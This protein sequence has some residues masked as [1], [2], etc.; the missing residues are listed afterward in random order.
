MSIKILKPAVM[1]TLVSDGR[2]GFRNLGIGPGGAMDYV[3]MKTSNFLTGSDE[4]AVLEMG[5]SSAEILFCNNG[6]ISITGMGFEAF[7][8]D[9]VVELWRPI[10]VRSD[11]ILKLKKKPTGAW[12]YLAVRGGWRA[13]KW[14]KS[15]T[16]NS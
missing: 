15:F 11:S 12:A 7:V 6:L 8:N 5:Y 13:Q 2:E 16:T 9:Q 14:L 3:A 10:Q 4:E 1:T